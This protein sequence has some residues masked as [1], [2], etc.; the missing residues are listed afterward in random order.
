MNKFELSAEIS[1]L[2]DEIDVTEAYYKKATKRYEA[3][4]NF[5]SESEL[6][7]Y[8]PDI[9][10]QGSI[11]L[12]TAIKPLTESGQYDIDIVCCLNSRDT[13]H[14]TQ[15][16]LKEMVGEV[17][18]KYSLRYSM[19]EPQESN[20]C[21]TLNYV[22]E[23]NFHIDILPAIPL[24]NRRDDSIA[25]TDK[26]NIYF[27]K[28]TDYWEISNPRGYAEWF[29]EQGNFSFFN[30]DYSEGLLYLRIEKIPDIKRKTHLQRIVQ[31]LKRHAEVMFEESLEYKPSSVIIT[32]LVA[33]IYRRCVEQ[34]SNFEELLLSVIDRIKE[35]I[36]YDEKNHPNI[37]NPVNNEEKLSLKWDKNIQYFKCFLKW[38]EQ[39]RSDFSVGNTDISINEKISYI[40]RSLHK[41]RNGIGVSLESLEHHKKNIWRNSDIQIPIEI[42]AEYTYPGFRSTKINSG[43]VLNKNGKIR[44]EITS[45]EIQDYDIYWQIT[46][47]GFEAQNAKCLRGGFYSSQCE[48]GKKIRIEKTSYKG[49]HYVEAYIIKNDVCYGK[50]SPFE[51]NITDSLTFNWFKDK[52][53][54]KG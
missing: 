45:A 18:K 44:F 22:D 13:H 17:I 38:I 31:L 24:K 28:H 42:T 33:K 15:K 40:R 30:E 5:I 41:G 6:K 4:A 47:T 21:W 27:D 52:Y 1:S 43:D 16:K 7:N 54:I 19:E 50:S 29:E 25:I 36:E 3:I 39:L 23:S 49:R 2:I 46:N 35:G 9:Y 8:R 37:Y 20:R 14:V 53:K 26:R 51:V 11:K 12:G 32:T 34:S 10:L 48:K